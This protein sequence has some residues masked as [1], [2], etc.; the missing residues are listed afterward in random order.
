MRT[1]QMLLTRLADWPEHR[2]NSKLY[3]PGRRHAQ[4]L[5]SLS[6][7]VKCTSSVPARKAECWEIV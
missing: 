1:W 3:L 7:T 4:R 2:E 5:S 6:G